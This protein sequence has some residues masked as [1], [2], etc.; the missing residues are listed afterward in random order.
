MKS[1]R[2]IICL[3]VVGKY[4]FLNVRKI[5]PG[6]MHFYQCNIKNIILNSHL[7]LL[8]RYMNRGVF[9]IQLIDMEL[10][11]FKL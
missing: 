6:V 2:I 11:F 4:Q 9:D 7:M 3:L 5:K 8:D 10:T 1:H